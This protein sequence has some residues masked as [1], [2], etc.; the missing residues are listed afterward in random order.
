MTLNTGEWSQAE[1]SLISTFV[2]ESD[3]V[4]DVGA[5]IGAMTLPFSKMVGPSGKV[6]AFE[7]QRI[8]SQALSANLAL[9]EVRNTAV[10]HAGIG[11]GTEPLDVPEVI[12]SEDANFGG[13][14]LLFDWKGKGASV[15]KVPQLTLDNIFID[16]CPSFIK[17]DV[18]GM[19]LTVLNG[20]SRI[21]QQCRPIVYIENNC[22][23]TSRDIITKFT[24]AGY[25]CHWQVNPYFNENNVKTNKSNIFG[26]AISINMICFSKEDVSAVERA[27]SLPEI[28]KVDPDS[29]R[30]LLEEY[31]LSFVGKEDQVL[32]QLGNL[33][34][35]ER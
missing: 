31:S 5:N 1:V 20:A 33:E 12:Y 18:E 3:I 35:C 28:T 17:I 34:S 8:L 26:E 32:S 24:N 21:L 16:Q 23:K 11:D 7:P 30:Y 27:A 25:L 19:E 22:K 2:K 6:L 4:V 29:G 14:S 15:E 10:Y 9:N 13:I